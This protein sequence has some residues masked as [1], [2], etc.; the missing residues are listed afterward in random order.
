MAIKCKIPRGTYDIL[1]EESYKRQFVYNTFMLVAR[2]FN[3]QEIVTPMFERSDVFERSVGD[4]SDIVQKEMYKFT[5]KKGRIFA[6]RPEGTAPVVRS[7]VENNLGM[8]GGATKLFYIGPMFRYDRPQ[9]GRYRQFYQYGVEH[10]GSDDPFVDAEVIAL[11]YR[12][13]TA[14]GLQNF[15]LE[16][17]NIGCPNCAKDYDAALVDYFTPHLDAMCSDCRERIKKNP[18]RLLDCKVPTCKAIAAN[19]PDMLQYLDDDCR[20]HFA[21]VQSYLTGMQ[22]PFTVNPRIVRGLDYYNKT[23]FEFTDTNLGAQNALIGGGRYN[24]L[25]AQFGGKDVPGIGFAGG[26][27]R[28]VLS[29][30]TEGCSFGPEPAPD[31]YL[32]VLGEAAKAAAA[33]IMY[34]LRA[35]GI[36]LEYDVEKTSMRA[37]MKAADKSGAHAVL[38]LGD[39][40]LISGKITLKWLETGNQETIAIDDIYSH[41]H[42]GAPI[43]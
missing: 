16:I 20:E 41:L 29:M 2:S 9:K 31:A 28:L 14:L 11:G 3:F 1:P 32:V 40:E 5:D 22:I 43:I 8:N 21:A 26:V 25:I 35:K 33:G 4:T 10:I 27:E 12:F 42:P 36:K 15:K 34:R 17:N 6:L 13:L 37:Q 39:D 30:E 7:Y 23:A 19:A 38:I 24:G 18:K